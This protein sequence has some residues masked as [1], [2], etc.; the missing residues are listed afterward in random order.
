MVQDTKVHPGRGVDSYPLSP[1][2]Q[3][4]LFRRLEQM[5][6]G[7]DLEQVVGE[8]HEAVDPAKFERA[9]REVIGR[10]A[11][12][13]TGFHLDDGAEPRQVVHPAAEARL[14]FQ[15]IEFGCDSEARRGLEEYLVADRREG[16]PSL[17]GPLLRVALLRGGP[18]HYWFVT[19]FHHLL[20]DG[21]AM[22]VMFREALDIHDALVRRTPLELPAPR[23]YRHYIDWLQTIDLDRAGQFW[24]GY[25]RGF[26]APTLLPLT[27]A[28]S[29]R[30]EAP[31]GA[32]ELGFRLTDAMHETLR[33]AARRHE[34]T[35]NT[36]LQ[37]AWGIVLS[38]YTGET[39]IVFGAVRACRHIPVEGADTMVGLLINTVPIRLQV[40]PGAELGPWLKALRQQWIAFREY[41]HTPLMK[42]QQWS[43]VGPGR[44]LFEAIFNYQEPS[45]DAALRLLGGRW[46]DRHL[47]LRSEP[48]YP[49]AIDAYGGESTIV[50]LLYDRCRFAD[51]AM[52]RLLGN[53]RV[54][55]E[56]FASAGAELPLGT[57]RFLTIRE[58]E[59]LLARGRGPALDY[60]RD[61]CVH[62]AVETCAG[63]WTER[64]AAADTNSVLTYGELDRAAGTLARRLRGCGV[65]PDT[66]VAVC[67]ERS[68]EMMVAWL[69]VWKA[70]GAFVPLDPQY[71]LE[72]LAF[73][74]ADS[75]APVVIT[76]SRLLGNLPPHP[77]VTE[78]ICFDA[79][80]CRE[81]AMPAP[82]VDEPRL[83]PGRRPTGSNLA[84]V[85]YTSGST[86]R[87]KGVQVEHRALMNLIT[88]HR[89]AFDVRPT[90]R[91]THLASPAFDASI[92]EIWPYLT[93]GASV[94]V[95]DEET[96]IAPAQLWTWLAEKQITI[97]FLPTP[98]LEAAMSEGRPATPALRTLLTGGD[99]LK[100]HPPKDFPCELIN[101]YG[102][103]ENTVVATAGQVACD[104]SDHAAPSIGRPIANTR[105]LILDRQLRLVPD[106][107][108]GELY[109]GGDSL[110]R[111]YLNQPELDAEKFVPDPFAGGPPVAECTSASAVAQPA[112]QRP[113]R[114]YRTGDLVRW[115][116]QGEIEFLG[117]IDGQVKI[118]GHR[119]EPGEIETVLQ[120]H[121]AVR[122]ALVHM[123]PDGCGELQLVGY[124]IPA[125]AGPANTTE[126][127]TVTEQPKEE[128]LGGE[129]TEHLRRKLPA[130]MVPSAIVLLE[131]WPVTPNGKINRDALPP[132]ATGTMESRVALAAP[133]SAIEETTA[134]IF[135]EILGRGPIGRDDNFF[136][137]GGHSLLAA[138]VVSRLNH[139]L[140]SALSVRS[141]FDQPTV[142]GLAREIEQ[143]RS[144][145]SR[146]RPQLK[147]RGLPA[148]MQVLQPN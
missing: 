95:P 133:A 121:P 22:A 69:A 48:T 136:E 91:A 37:A 105:A 118:R 125:G 25:L 111:G 117:R 34:V 140:Q 82:A 63:R 130:Y 7:V 113:P 67:M 120:A 51:E 5:S 104:G 20:L 27:R 94:H 44:P 31:T 93:A 40:E 64:I 58:S 29:G 122:E 61:T 112:D 70:G 142:A 132:P 59:K 119:I 143:R 124:V 21:R 90:D 99:K 45:W 73:Q 97:S 115:T 146:P 131:A 74:L 106:G 147:R 129:L 114:L 88:W 30:L 11:I 14:D 15:H 85:I 137:L 144:S 2:Q 52:A 39:D 71:P 6:P 135:R 9:W 46:A 141:I 56:A 53:F 28:G 62:E 42:V 13:R 123:R 102:P 89:K 12:L 24:R 57:L 18:A 139:A 41:E 81:A 10:H 134:R 110:A 72:R 60:P 65:G 92:W 55:L 108:P 4:M 128:L 101:N 16:F 33:A 8:L 103:T 26:A 19:T 77:S 83:P 36:L 138:Q 148:E 100:R 47:E 3:G 80:D 84:Y 35:M 116:G 17:A 109:L 145:A 126:H 98:L 127:T 75:A 87:P 96:R 54:T 32:G 107:A 23:A 38:R 50:K 43:D 78:T 68:V 66:L 79:S 86:G 76:Q 49:L 1:M